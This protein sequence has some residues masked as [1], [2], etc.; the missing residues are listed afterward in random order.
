[1]RKRAALFFCLV[2]S[3]ACGP[4]I[5]RETILDRDDMR[6]ELRRVVQENSPIAGAYD[7]PVL[8]ADVRIAHILASLT[9]ED[10]KGRRRPTIRAEHVHPLAEGIA[11][12][13]NKATPEDEI[14][15][16]TFASDRRLLVFN[17]ERVT[18]FRAHFEADVFVIEFY[19]IEDPLEPGPRDEKY[20][21]PVNPPTWKPG[22]TLVEGRS[23]KLRGRRTVRVDWRSPY[24]AQPA[25]LQVQGGK[26]RRRTILMEAEEET[27]L[28]ARPSEL[29]D[30]QIRAMDQIEAARRS[31]IISES[32]FQRRRVLV[33]EGRLEEAGYGPESPD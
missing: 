30:A 13:V 12:A 6:V 28:P 15:A 7:H 25:N 11:K 14:A 8:I 27:E 16:A 4:R 20:Q 23:Q 9:H 2:L 18:A 10:P 22:F 26:L 5:I 17:S 33:L 1:M 3:F 29:D 31:G 32:E 21:I 24:F 19:A